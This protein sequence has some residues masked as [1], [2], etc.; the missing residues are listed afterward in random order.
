METKMMSA[1]K[2]TSG[3]NGKGKPRKKLLM[4]AL[5]STRFM[6]LLAIIV[7]LPLVV[8]LPLRII[9]KKF[10]PVT[11]V[12][13]GVSKIASRR[14]RPLERLLGNYE[15]EPEHITIKSPGGKGHWRVES[16]TY[17][18]TSAQVAPSTEI[19]LYRLRDIY[20]Q[21]RSS[22]DGSPKLTGALMVGTYAC[23]DISNAQIRCRLMEGG[24]LVTAHDAEV[25][26]G[27]EFD[28]KFPDY[29]KVF[30]EYNASFDLK[31]Y[32]NLLITFDW[33][34]FRFEPS[35]ETVLPWS[36]RLLRR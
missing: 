36:K 22:K 2:A 1:V 28:Y 25:S 18:P 11:F 27:G 8:I 34:N 21:I 10:T 15:T 6:I 16:S 13:E 35:Q 7:F 24:R 29:V 14:L 26:S 23:T 19:T 33:R 30:T 32:D 4:C 17:L 12:S 31:Q 9:P 5:C 20:L 3:E